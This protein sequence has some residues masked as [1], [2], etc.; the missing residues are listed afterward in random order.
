MET[1]ILLL[2]LA[3]VISL[4]IAIYQFLKSKALEEELLNQDTVNQ[5]HNIYTIEQLLETAEN[6]SKK[7]R[8]S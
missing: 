3:T 1:L 5:Q 8:K 7:E 2:I 4:C 6:N